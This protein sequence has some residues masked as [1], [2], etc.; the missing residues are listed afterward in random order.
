[1]TCDA[2]TADEKDDRKLLED[3]RFN[4]LL[5]ERTYSHAILIVFLI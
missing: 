5:H 1:M 4:D 3:V 2:A